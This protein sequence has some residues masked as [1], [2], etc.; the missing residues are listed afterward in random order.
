M[1]QQVKLIQI[2]KPVTAT[3]F[4]D[5]KNQQVCGLLKSGELLVAASNPKW[6]KP[7][8]IFCKLHDD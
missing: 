7:I 1:T 5:V 6:G 8:I 3:F 2:C 4:S